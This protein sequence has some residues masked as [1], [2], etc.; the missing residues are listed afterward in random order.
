MDDAMLDARDE[1]VNFLNLIVPLPDPDIYRVPVMID[2]SKWEV[3]SAALKCL[4][5][6]A[7]VNS[8]SLKEGEE[9][10]LQHAREIKT[11]GGGCGGDGLRR[12]GG[13]PIPMNAKSRFV[14]E[15]TGCSPR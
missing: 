13:R 4:Q 3:I 7:I 14:P 10:F 1:M 9:L 12:T 5:G 8:I 6:K 2:S 11:D 15:P